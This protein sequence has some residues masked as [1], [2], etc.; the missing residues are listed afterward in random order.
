MRKLPSSN[1]YF[2]VGGIILLLCVPFFIENIYY[3]HIFI[4]TFIFIILLLSLNLVA[5]YAGQVSVCHAA[6]YGVGAYTSALLTLQLDISSW[7]ALPVATIFAG[8]LGFLIGYPA[9]RL[10]GHYFAIA[11][12]CFGLIVTMIF[13]NWTGLTRGPMGLPGIAPPNPIPLPFL[14]EISFFS[15]R[16]F[17][18]LAF[19]FVLFTVYVNYRLINSRIGMAFVAIREEMDLAESVGINTMRLKLL[20]FTISAALAGIAGTL[21]AHYVRFISPESFTFIDSFYLIAGIVI[22][23]KG[24]LGGPIIGSLILVA[25]PEYLRALEQYQWLIYGGLIIV[26]LIFMPNGIWGAIKSMSESIERRKTG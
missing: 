26:V 2:S 3:I 5:G 25:L 14:S 19:A 6:F 17:Y 8:I 21:Y 4:M 13:N 18:Y 20:A 10:R 22:G 12:L 16:N 23:G 11:T 15:K 7:L 24:S 9:L 1:M